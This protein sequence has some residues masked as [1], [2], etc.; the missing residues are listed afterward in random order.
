MNKRDQIIR[1]ATR[2]FS[3]KGFENTALSEVCEEAGVSKGLIFHHFKSKD[4]L[5]RVI[6]SNTTELIAELNRSENDERPAQERLLTLL[7]GFFNQLESDKFFVQL[8]LNMML[9]PNTRAVLNDLIKERS[10]LILDS[11]MSIF[12]AIDPEQ[13][14]LRSYALIAELDG[15]ALNYICIFEDYPLTEMKDHLLK[16]YSLSYAPL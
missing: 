16:R 2:L 12:K 14:S 1:V 3:E 5:L 7:E 4:D 6:F 10:A 13:A 15:I 9:Q 8:N 11:V